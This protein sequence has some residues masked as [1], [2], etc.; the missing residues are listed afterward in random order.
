MRA[1]S[2]LS[3]VLDD[4]N[5]KAN[6]SKSL[7]SWDVHSSVREKQERRKLQFNSIQFNSS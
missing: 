7:S 1:C 5:T 6:T 4:G 2:L 3:I